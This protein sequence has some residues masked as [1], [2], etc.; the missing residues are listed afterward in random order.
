[1]FI[2]LYQIENWGSVWS[3]K[4]YMIINVFLNGPFTAVLYQGT[5]HMALTKGTVLTFWHQSF[6]FKF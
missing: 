3:G 5:E 2:Q 6:T 4:V 1:M